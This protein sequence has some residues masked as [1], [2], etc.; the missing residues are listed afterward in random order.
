M[1]CRT[2][3]GCRQEQGTEIAVSKKKGGEILKATP[4]LTEDANTPPRK[5]SNS[6]HSTMSSPSTT[7]FNPYSSHS[8]RVQIPQSYIIERT[9]SSPCIIDASPKV[10][11]YAKRTVGTNHGGHHI[12][13]LTPVTRNTTRGTATVQNANATKIGTA[14]MTSADLSVPN[15]LHKP[16]V[17]GYRHVQKLEPLNHRNS[18]SYSNRPTSKSNHQIIRPRG[19]SCIW[20]KGPTQ[21]TVSL[22][23]DQSRPISPPSMFSLRATSIVTPSASGSA[24]VATNVTGSKTKLSSS[25][26]TSNQL[27]P[28]TR[29]RFESP[30]NRFS[31]PVNL[32]TRVKLDRNSYSLPH[33]AY[34]ND[35]DDYEGDGTT[36]TAAKQ[37]L[38][39]Q[40]QE[41][42]SP[43]SMI[44]TPQ[45]RSPDEEVEKSLFI[46]YQPS[47]D[48]SLASFGVVPEELDD[49]FLPLRTTNKLRR[50][51]EDKVVYVGGGG[52]KGKIGYRRGSID[53]EE[54]DTYTHISDSQSSATSIPSIR[55]AVNIR[56]STQDSMTTVEGVEEEEEGNSYINS[57]FD[58]DDD[59]LS[60]AVVASKESLEELDTLFNNGLNF[61]TA[62]TATKVKV[63]TTGEGTKYVETKK[64]VNRIRHM[65]PQKEEEVYQ[66]LRTLEVDKDNNDYFAEAASS[67]F[68]TGKMNNNISDRFYNREQQYE[69]IEREVIQDIQESEG[70]E[71]KRE[72]GHEQPKEALKEAQLENNPK[73]ALKRN[74][75]KSSSNNVVMGRNIGLFDRNKNVMNRS[76]KGRNSGFKVSGLYR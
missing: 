9:R 4:I 18:G 36:T 32:D 24:T 35:D 6:N 20:T 64:K 12:S 75:I 27:N 33:P 30:Q 15:T 13:Q 70:D 50:S 10:N 51:S 26:Q 25:S 53:D 54:E 69:R 19:V 38:Q 11:F 8:P 57:T 28:K 60:T 66:W 40:Q 21:R 58:D 59:D 23:S 29:P 52:G 49:I 65:S 17:V 41:H 68:L 42:S 43:E 71:Q 72:H 1:Y 7:T 67:K 47:R 61:T 5:R 62:A 22:P 45:P 74:N 46:P 44:G 16:P 37:Q 55:M 2:E 34:N 63:S 39:Q 48:S 3:K 14:G 76:A 31:F 73:E 56:S